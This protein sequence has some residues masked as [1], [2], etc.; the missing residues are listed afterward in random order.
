MIQLNPLHRSVRIQLWC[1][2]QFPNISWGILC[3]SL[4][5]RQYAPLT[6]DQMTDFMRW[7]FDSTE[8]LARIA[9]PYSVSPARSGSACAQRWINI[10]GLS[11]HVFPVFMGRESGWTYF[12]P[13][14]IHI[15]V[16][17]ILKIVIVSN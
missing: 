8:K 4:D 3:P 9:C 13:G 1:L 12:G 2:R 7:L 14:F 16:E 17:P 15:S 11:R 10:Q 5:S 6:I